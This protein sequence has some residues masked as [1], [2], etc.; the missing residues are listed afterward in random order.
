MSSNNNTIS[1]L[2]PGTISNNNTNT[3][4][5]INNNNNIQQSAPSSTNN[6]IPIRNY[7]SNLQQL[8]RTRIIYNPG[9]GHAT[10][11]VEDKTALYDMFDWLAK[12][13]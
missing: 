2:T 12:S 9:G 7:H 10:F 6:N 8:I 4:N 1:S 3:S 5:N 13:D 11:L